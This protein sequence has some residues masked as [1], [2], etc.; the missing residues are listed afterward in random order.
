MKCKHCP[1]GRLA[2]FIF[3]LLLWGAEEEEEEEEAGLGWMGGRAG[4]KKN[5]SKEDGALEASWGDA[6]SHRRTEKMLLLL[7]HALSC[8]ALLND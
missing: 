2:R 4:E 5:C 8:S 3:L 1:I 7:G 6:S